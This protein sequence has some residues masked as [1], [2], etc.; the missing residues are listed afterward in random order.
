MT[1]KNKGGINP[2][3]AAVAGAVVGAGV[4]IAGAVVLG[5]KKN[6][7]KINKVLNN[8]KDQAVDYVEGVQK[9]AEDKK[10]EIEKEFVKGKKITQK[11][12][13]DAKKVMHLK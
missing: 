3:V 5:D 13:K 10:S 7:E 6:R 4:G 2:V 12:V 9:Q 1:N 8:V 11:T